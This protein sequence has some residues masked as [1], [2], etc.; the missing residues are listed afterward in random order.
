MYRDKHFFARPEMFCFLLLIF[1]QNILWNHARTPE[2]LGLA[3]EMVTALASE[4]PYHFPAIWATAWRGR[5]N[6]SASGEGGG[7]GAR[8]CPDASV[9]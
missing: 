8:P 7:C 2:C 1:L 9:G 6:W 3:G 5:P 4:T